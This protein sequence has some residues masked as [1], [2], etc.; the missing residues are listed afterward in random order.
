MLIGYFIRYYAKRWVM[1]FILLTFGTIFIWDVLPMATR[2]VSWERM[3]NI[4][5]LVLCSGNIPTKLGQVVPELTTSYFT[6]IIG[7]VLIDRIDPV[8]KRYH[9][10]VIDLYKP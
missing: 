6:L 4:T 5:T 2:R 8:V 9:V 3:A 10:S 1:R 7:V